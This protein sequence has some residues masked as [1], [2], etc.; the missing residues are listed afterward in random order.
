[1]LLVRWIGAI[2]KQMNRKTE[3]VQTLWIWFILTMPDYCG[4]GTPRVSCQVFC[5]N[6]DLKLKILLYFHAAVSDLAGSAWTRSKNMR[7]PSVQLKEFLFQTKE[8]KKKQEQLFHVTVINM[9]ITALIAAICTSQSP[10]CS[11]RQNSLLELS[12]KITPDKLLFLWNNE[13]N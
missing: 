6:G 12:S 1:M 9:M 11:S 4:P 5:V 8:H 10:P 3:S 7:Y 2:F 13:K